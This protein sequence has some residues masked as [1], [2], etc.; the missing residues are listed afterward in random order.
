MQL[1]RLISSI[2]VFSLIITS[3]QTKSNDVEKRNI[4]EIIALTINKLSFPLPPPPNFI[5]DSIKNSVINQKALDSLKAI[6][7]NIALYPKIEGSTLSILLKDEID[8][9]SINNLS[10]HEIMFADTIILKKSRD[11]KE[12]HLLFMFSEISFN[13]NFSTAKASI[14][15]SRSA[16]WGQGYDV[17]YKKEESGKW[18]IERSIKTEKW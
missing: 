2:L 11:W 14:G 6:K 17:Y 5:G 4:E 10:Q 13:K 3:C 12:Y 16:L 18:A 7:M 8:I 15:V 1:V 9:N